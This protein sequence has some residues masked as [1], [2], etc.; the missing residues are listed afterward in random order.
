MKKK[1]LKKYNEKNETKR[2]KKTLLLRF[3]LKWFLKIEMTICKL[4]TIFP[5]SVSQSVNLFFPG[6]KYV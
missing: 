2:K 1:L 6:G 5:Y 4:F 3:V